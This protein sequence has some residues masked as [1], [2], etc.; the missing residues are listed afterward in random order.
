MVRPAGPSFTAPQGLAFN[1]HD[2]MVVEDRK[3]GSVPRHVGGSDRVRPDGPTA[4]GGVSTGSGSDRVRPAGPTVTR[5]RRLNG[6][7]V[8]LS[9]I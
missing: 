4:K 2:R 8:L 7:L 6:D 5:S 3:V 9:V 1:S